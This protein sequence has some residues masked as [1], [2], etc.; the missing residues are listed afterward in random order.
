MGQSPREEMVSAQRS[1]EFT[2][3]VG[4]QATS[5]NWGLLR[6]QQRAQKGDNTVDRVALI[7]VEQIITKDSNVQCVAEAIW[8]VA[9]LAKGLRTHFPISK[10]YCGMLLEKFKEKNMSVCRACMEALGNL[11]SYCFTL[12]DV[13]DDVHQ[14]L[15]HQNPKVKQ[16][17]LEWMKT[18]IDSATKQ[19]AA[20]LVPVYNAAIANCSDDATPLTRERALAVLVSFCLKATSMSA[21]D[22]ITAKLDDTRKKKLDELL[23]EARSGGT[24][25]KQPSTATTAAAP[26]KKSSPANDSAAMEVD[27]PP[28][29]PKKAANAKQSSSKA[30]SQPKAA[31]S[32]PENKCKSARVNQSSDIFADR[33]FRGG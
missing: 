31:T 3:D 16:C 26:P 28:P 12:L 32:K 25:A 30:P 8:C 20:K 24:K 5:G 15:N 6:D 13:Q 9:A 21:I 19:A 7:V 17:T 4:Q 18:C 10:S 23:K 22:K 27:K 29:K 2:E 33:Y 11:N 14:A 1:T